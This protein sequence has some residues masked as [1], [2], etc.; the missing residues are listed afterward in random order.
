ME[1]QSEPQAPPAPVET[2]TYELENAPP[3]PRTVAEVLEDSERTK[4][5]LKTCG[6]R[7]EEY[8]RQVERLAELNAELAGLAQK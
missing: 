2:V 8:Q 4:A 5:M 3:R 6:L 1:E 7:T